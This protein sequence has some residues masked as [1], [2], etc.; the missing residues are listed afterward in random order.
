MCPYTH[1]ELAGMQ[2]IE[3]NM[4]VLFF[5]Q[6][7]PIAQTY[8]MAL[9]FFSMH[10]FASHLRLTAILILVHIVA[11]IKHRNLNTSV[12]RPFND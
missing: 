8:V 10:V 5:S 4:R 6:L 9:I 1:G 2:H 3:G 12:F 7:R 11:P